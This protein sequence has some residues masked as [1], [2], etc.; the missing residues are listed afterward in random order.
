MVQGFDIAAPADR[1]SLHSIHVERVQW[2]C[3]NSRQQWGN[4]H[5]VALGHKSRAPCVNWLIMRA[6]PMV[7]SWYVYIQFRWI[8]WNCFCLLT[9]M[10]AIPAPG[11]GNKI[12]CFSPRASHQRQINL[13]SK[14][15][16]P[17]SGFVC[18]SLHLRGWM[19][20]TLSSRT[21]AIV[22]ARRWM[23]FSSP[24]VRRAAIYKTHHLQEFPF[25]FRSNE[26]QLPLVLE[27]LT[28]RCSTWCSIISLAAQ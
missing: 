18:S 10:H 27:F 28:H 24:C 15:R 3:I 17:Y 1:A 8:C 26:D 7:E 16:L 21:S 4:T 22:E 12:D 19:Y 11:Q 9:M 25:T 6:E 2:L 23:K 14:N 20:F 13:P 5:K